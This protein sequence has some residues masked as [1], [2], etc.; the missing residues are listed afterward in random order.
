[1]VEVDVERL[2]SDVRALKDLFSADKEKWLDWCKERGFGYSCVV[3]EQDHFFAEPYALVA[4]GIYTLRA[5]LR[6]RLH[7]MN[8]P[9][10]IED[11]NR[12]MRA[13]GKGKLCQRWNRLEWNTRIA[14]AY[15][16]KYALVGDYDAT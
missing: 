9:M 13:A 3:D 7:R 12:T 2:A 6:G 5:Y 1:M 16:T 15:A 8:P 10:A 14:S 4:T 11:F